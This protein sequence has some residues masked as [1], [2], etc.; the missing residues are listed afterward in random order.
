MEHTNQNQFFQYIFGQ[1]QTFI[2]SCTNYCH[3]DVLYS[4]YITS[5]TTSYIS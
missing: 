2:V 1:A 5:Y 4:S 3:F